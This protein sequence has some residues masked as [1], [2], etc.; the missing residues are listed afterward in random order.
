MRMIRK[1]QVTVINILGDYNDTDSVIDSIIQ[2]IVVI[3]VI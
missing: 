2:V 1:I 3:N